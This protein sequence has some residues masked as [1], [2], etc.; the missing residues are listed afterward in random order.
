M[1]I[2]FTGL[3]DMGSAMAV[4]LIK[5]GHR[6]AVYNCTRAKADQPA[7]DG[8]VARNAGLRSWIDS[9]QGVRA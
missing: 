1:S 6:L 8:A 7:A 4:C 9:S 2:G 5:G 3:D